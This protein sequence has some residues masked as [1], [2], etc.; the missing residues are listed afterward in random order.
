MDARRAGVETRLGCPLERSHLLLV[1]MPRM[2]RDI[3]VDALSKAD[4][5][6]VVGEV[7]GDRAR[8]VV[9]TTSVDF[10]ITGRDD[11]RLA[12]ELLESRPCVKVLAMI[13]DGRESALYELRPERVALGELSA[14][15]LV[16]IVREARASAKTDWS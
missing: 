12:A 7:D 16:A 13:D 14:Q 15:R 11:A 3:V 5:V 1:D 8:E 6:D 4:D 9:Q 10:V 2:L